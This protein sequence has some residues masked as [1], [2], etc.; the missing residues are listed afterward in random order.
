[1]RDAHSIPWPRSCGE[2]HRSGC[3]GTIARSWRGSPPLRPRNMINPASRRVSDTWHRNLLTIL[4]CLEAV[5]AGLL[6][7]SSEGAMVRVWA[8]A[9]QNVLGLLVG[10]IEHDVTRQDGWSVSVR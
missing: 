9:E 3:A 4:L 5:L 10:E 1:M 7:H 8:V 2:T 6:I